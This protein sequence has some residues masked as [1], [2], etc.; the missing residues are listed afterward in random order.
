ML[1]KNKDNTYCISSHQVWLPGVY[2]DT[3]AANRAFKYDDFILQKLQEAAN[4]R[5]GGQGGTITNADLDAC[6]KKVK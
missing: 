6:K 5:A 3:R 1:H 2:E 4:I